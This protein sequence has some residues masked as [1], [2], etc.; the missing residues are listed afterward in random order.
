MRVYDKNLESNGE[1][2]CVR[3]DVE[4]SQ[5]RSAMLRRA[6]DDQEFIHW[7]ESLL[8]EGGR[9]LKT[10]HLAMI[11]EYCMRRKNIE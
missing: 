1:Y 10:R 8:I 9:K 6:S 7:F 3:W 4:F 2:D 5:K 11:E